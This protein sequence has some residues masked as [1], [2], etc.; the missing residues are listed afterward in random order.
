M[1]DEIDWW[2]MHGPIAEG[3]WQLIHLNQNVLEGFSICVLKSTQIM[4]NAWNQGNLDGSYNIREEV[5]HSRQEDVL[6]SRH[7]KKREEEE[8]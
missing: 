4:S 8:G 6:F 1:S 5:M 7:R 3:A 2:P